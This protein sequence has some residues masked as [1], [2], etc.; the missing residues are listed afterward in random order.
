MSLHIFM[1]SLKA[2]L[3]NLIEEPNFYI[4]HVDVKGEDGAYVASVNN[5]TISSSCL[6]DSGDEDAVSSFSSGQMD[7][8]IELCPF[9]S[10]ASSGVSLRLS[11]LTPSGGS[12]MVLC[13]VLSRLT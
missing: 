13:L 11:L 2:I 12:N 7:R 8:R 4:L 1:I 5:V 3:L 10:L 9:F 6:S